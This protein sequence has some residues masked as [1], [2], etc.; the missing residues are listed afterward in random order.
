MGR[1]HSAATIAKLSRP[2]P[3]FR[4][5]H[6]HDHLHRRTEDPMPRHDMERT[7][8]RRTVQQQRVRLEALRAKLE[9]LKPTAA[10]AL[11]EG[12]QRT[13]ADLEAKFAA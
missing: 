9:S 13:I 1:K 11:R 3:R 10:P 4:K 7:P 2:L 5:Q 6:V 8:I 12:L